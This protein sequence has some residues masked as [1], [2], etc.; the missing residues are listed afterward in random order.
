MSKSK[1]CVDWERSAI[2]RWQNLSV[3]AW[4]ECSNRPIAPPGTALPECGW[5][6]FI[7]SGRCECQP[8]QVPCGGFRRLTVFT[9][10][11]AVFAV[12]DREDRNHALASSRL[13]QLLSRQAKLVNV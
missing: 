2:S 5:K 10:T 8:R 1:R 12:L 13:A 4:T 11:S 3:K 7:G 6:V 9:D